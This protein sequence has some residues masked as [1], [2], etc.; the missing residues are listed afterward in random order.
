[1]VAFLTTMHKSTFRKILRHRQDT[2]YY[3]P[4]PLIRVL[5]SGPVR[6][7]RWRPLVS[8]GLFADNRP[9]YIA[10]P[11]C[12]LTTWSVLIGSLSCLVSA[13]AMLPILCDYHLCS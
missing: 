11:S 8:V 9:A 10:R 5:A 3:Q 7:D 2:F 4:V 12:L 13:G 6:Q 1:M